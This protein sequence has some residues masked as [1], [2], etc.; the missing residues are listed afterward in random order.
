MKLDII[1]TCLFDIVF[2]FKGESGINIFDDDHERDNQELA[3]A[4]IG[5]MRLELVRNKT[6]TKKNMYSAFANHQYLSERWKTI[7]MEDHYQSVATVN[8]RMVTLVVFMSRRY[9]N[10]YLCAWKE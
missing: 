8:R 3:I 1:Y 2:K 4:M 10:S 7:Q 6:L 5:K 9:R